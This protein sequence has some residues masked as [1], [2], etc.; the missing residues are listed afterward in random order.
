MMVG[1]IGAKPLAAVVGLDALSSLW[2]STTRLFSWF[3]NQN[4]RRNR[5]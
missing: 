1:D 2:R 5:A 4:G 3:G